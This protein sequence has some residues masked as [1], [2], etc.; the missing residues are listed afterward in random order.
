MVQV[1]LGKFYGKNN[2]DS[3]ID[4]QLHISE[5]GESL[6]TA[7]NIFSEGDIIWEDYLLGE[8]EESRLYSLIGVNYKKKTVV[9]IGGPRKC[10]LFPHLL[11]VGQRHIR[12]ADSLSITTF[13]VRID[14]D[15]WFYES[16]RHAEQN[17]IPLNLRPTFNLKYDEVTTLEIH[18]RHDMI[19]GK[20]VTV[21][22]FKSQKPQ[23]LKYF[24]DAVHYLI[25][26][27]SF[28]CRAALR[29]GD[30][31]FSDSEG[32]EYE[33]HYK[34]AFYPVTVEH[35]NNLFNHN[36]SDLQGKFTRWIEIYDK[37]PAIFKLYFLARL[38]KLDGT[39]RFLI[40]AQALECFH[41]KFHDQELH[42]VQRVEAVI[43]GKGYHS[44]LK[45]VGG[46]ER[47]DNL[48]LLIRDTR[49]YFTHYNDKLKHNSD[50]QDLPFLTFKIELIID[51]YLLEEIGFSSGYYETIKTAVIDDRFNRKENL[52][53][54]YLSSNAG[55]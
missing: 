6:L 46:S 17:Y 27:L 2:P 51:L 21:A 19:S 15:S 16:S 32:L 28:A 1:I 31:R 52:H 12:S 30:I 45:Q 53:R 24:Q 18:S 5:D 20:R 13:S 42:F 48:H 3:S 4:A 26:F 38:T 22:T 8:S 39:V 50:E 40:T 10:E 36:V 35:N 25:T 44:I 11:I 47:V 14:C 37:A 41:R 55:V 49:N 34:P 43:N 29:H 9:S 33:L 7:N 23:R 54:D